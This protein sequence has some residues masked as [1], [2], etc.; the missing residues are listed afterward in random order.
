[1][2]NDL[3]LE[4][5]NIIKNTKEYQEYKRLKDLIDIKYSNLII[6]FKT[7]ESL[8]L[9]AKKYEAFHPN[10]KDIQNNFVMAKKKLY[11]K[12]E[13]KEFFKYER[14]IQKMLNEDINEL[15]NSIS[16]KFINNKDI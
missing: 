5:T 4:Y 9:E 7:K 10:F 13:V 12:T 1:M 11:E 14:I 16:N 6:D 2:L 15:K 8:Y 3:A